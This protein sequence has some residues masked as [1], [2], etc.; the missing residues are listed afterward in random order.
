M[1][2]LRQQLAAAKEQMGA[3]FP[4]EA[5][6]AEKSARLAEVNAAL[7][8]DHRENEDLGDD[9]PDEGDGPAAPQRKKSDRER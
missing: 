5:E 2:D 4:Q 7:N 9:T 1:A 6:L 8:L 3:P